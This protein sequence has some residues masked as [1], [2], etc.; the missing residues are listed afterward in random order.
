MK[1][2]LFVSTV[3]VRPVPCIQR[4]RFCLKYTEGFGEIPYSTDVRKYAGGTGILC[5]GEKITVV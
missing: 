2:W 4:V 1:G 3:G 5:E